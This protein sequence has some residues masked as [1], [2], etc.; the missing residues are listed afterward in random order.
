MRQAIESSS[1]FEPFSPSMALATPLGN[2]ET[3]YFLGSALFVADKTP[4]R[5]T[6]PFTVSSVSQFRGCQAVDAD[7]RL[8]RLD[9]EFTV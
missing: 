9:G 5:R 2:S 7:A 4:F 6:A 8:R 3:K 1:L